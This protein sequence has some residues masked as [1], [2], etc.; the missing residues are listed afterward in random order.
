M[1]V[2]EHLARL[3]LAPGDV[4]AACHTPYPHPRFP[5]LIVGPASVLA[6]P[7]GREADPFVRKRSARAIDGY[8]TL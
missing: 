4:G 1:S 8:Q 2:A 7:E 5:S 6:L 3:P